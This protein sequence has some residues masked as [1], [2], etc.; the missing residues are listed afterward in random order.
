[1]TAPNQATVG[2][3]P[4][5]QARGIQPG[6]RLGCSSFSFRLYS[7]FRFKT[8]LRT[9]LMTSRGGA[10]EP[11]RT[12]LRT[13]SRVRAITLLC[14]CSE[15]PKA[16]NR[17]TNLLTHLGFKEVVQ[18]PTLARSS[19][20]KV[21]WFLCFPFNYSKHVSISFQSPFRRSLMVLVSSRCRAYI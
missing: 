18:T 5:D 4:S 8:S 16:K 9:C 10:C 6:S 17:N 7:A 15:K 13:R 14:V 2:L 19:L 20:N 1:M 12:R 11:S 21:H 3:G